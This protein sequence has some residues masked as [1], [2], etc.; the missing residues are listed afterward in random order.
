MDKEIF[1]LTAH[2]DHED[3]V[4][5]TEVIGAFKNFD[6]ARAEMAIEY[7]KELDRWLNEGY[8]EED[9]TR[10]ERPERMTLFDNDCGIEYTEFEI[11]STILC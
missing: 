6:D 1:I 7:G 5:T 2:R 3:D 11:T 8:L 4:N 10:H 9:I